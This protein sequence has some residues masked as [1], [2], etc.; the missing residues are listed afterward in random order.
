M[1][2]LLILSSCINDQIVENTDASKEGIQKECQ[3]SD[4]ERATQKF[5]HSQESYP[6]LNPSIKIGGI[7]E[8]G[9][10]I[11][12]LMN[13][14]LVAIRGDTLYFSN[15]NNFGY[16]YSKRL[17]GSDLTQLSSDKPYFINVAGDW[18][19]YVN[20]CSDA[21]DDEYMKLY[22]VSV[23]GIIRQSLGGRGSFVLV[24]DELIYYV[25]FDDNACLY[26]MRLDGTD[27][28]K[29]SDNGVLRF[30]VI[31][32]R[33]Y[34]ICNTKNNIYGMRIDGSDNHRVG[35]ITADFFHIVNDIIYFLNSSSNSRL[36]SMDIDGENMRRLHDNRVQFINVYGDK[37]LFS[38]A[39]IGMR[40]GNLYSMNTN[41]TDKR[42]LMEAN[43]S[44]IHII[45]D[46]IYFI[47]TSGDI[48]SELS[49]ELVTMGLDGS[50][51]ISVN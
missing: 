20:T 3:T 14:G 17:D 51:K 25:N 6:H 39:S 22:R 5:T 34:Y 15:K 35:E 19:Y 37:I 36:Y 44:D 38:E 18:I 30:N 24:V 23:D 2:F 9:N 40:G 31:D 26:S 41:G 8:L 10:S 1:C 28:R 7:E 48:N 12:N 16:L 11:G 42:L 45:N 27:K 33:I 50:D 47:I 29:L 49:F 46:R 4:D 32:D 13:G 21:G 43:T